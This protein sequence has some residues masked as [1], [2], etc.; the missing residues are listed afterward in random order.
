MKI[1]KSTELNSDTALPVV[2]ELEGTTA[3][4]WFEI[5][6]SRITRNYG[7]SGN[8]KNP[9]VSEI[10]SLSDAISEIYNDA[11]IVRASKLREL[12]RGKGQIDNDLGD[13]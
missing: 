1:I 7:E 5:S 13:S 6:M 12:H 4:I 2:V 8:I 11:D 3:Y 10:V 9:L